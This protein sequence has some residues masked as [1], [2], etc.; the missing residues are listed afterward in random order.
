MP[1]RMGFHE[2]AGVPGRQAGTV[3][4]TRLLSPAGRA[5]VPGLGASV[6]AVHAVGEFGL[7]QGQGMGCD[8]RTSLPSVCPLQHRNLLIRIS[9]YDANRAARK[10]ARRARARDSETAEV[11]DFVVAVP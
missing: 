8:A 10:V 11:L 3:F 1:R 6:V 2:S 4:R 9:F 5:S 7:E